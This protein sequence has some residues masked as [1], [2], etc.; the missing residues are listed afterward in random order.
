[1]GSTALEAR[2]GA[3]GPATAAIDRA[4]LARF[5]LGNEALAREVLELFA[6]QA[7]I[8]LKALQLA[9]GDRDWQEAAHTLKGA[10]AAVGARQ[11][12]R[13]AELAE[14]VGRGPRG[15]ARAAERELAIGAIAEA[16]AA[17]CRE[18]TAMFGP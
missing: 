14:R 17:A 18:I 5:T 15:A 8:Y 7:P 12:Q 6:A 10:A 4:Y 11:L 9:A 16:T 3:S 2:A 13:L 1:M